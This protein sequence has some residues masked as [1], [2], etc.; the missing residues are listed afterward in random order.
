LAA[1]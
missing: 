1:L